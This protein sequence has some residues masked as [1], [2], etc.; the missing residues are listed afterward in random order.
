MKK[1]NWKA[2]LVRSV[3]IAAAA[4]IAIAL[5][6]ELGMKYSATAGIITVLSIQ[7]TKRETLK[8]ARNRGLAFLC[9]LALAAVCFA[10]LGYTLWAFA[11]YLLLF[12]LLCLTVGWGEAIAMDSVLITH[13]LTEQSMA[14]ALLLNEALLFVIGT[15]LGILVNLHL[16]RK[17]EAFRELSEEVD[18]QMKGILHRMSCWL[19]KEDKSEYGPGCFEK[20]DKALEEAKL[21]A[22]ANY[23][24]A[25][26]Q[27]GTYE[28][29][30][31]KMREQQSVILKEIYANI[32]R[33]AYLPEQAGQVAELFGRIER[34]YHRDNTVE[35]LLEELDALLLRMKE[36]ELP[37]TREEF[38]ARA[39]LYYILMQI[40]KLLELKRDFMRRD[41]NL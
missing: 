21:C 7:N 25:L 12:A 35:G 24:N 10:L 31:V 18:N 29:D 19:P 37:E 36:Q 20:L 17:E 33:I 30:Y 15:A 41:K 13:F 27:S 9:A 6:G 28:L 2:Q 22:A 34:D 5:A 38:E 16:H 39:I 32:K 11:V 40:R 14:P 23:N 3:K 26:L 4:V 1:R 8:S